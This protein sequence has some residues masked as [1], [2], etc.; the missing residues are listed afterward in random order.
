MLFIYLLFNTQKT[1][2]KLQQELLFQAIVQVSSW[3]II[4]HIVLN[5]HNGKFQ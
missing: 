5:L 3:K 2:K 1:S 4:Q